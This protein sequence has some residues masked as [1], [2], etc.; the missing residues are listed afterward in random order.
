VCKRIVA[1]SGDVVVV[2][3]N[4]WKQHSEE[5]TVIL[6]KNKGKL[7]SEIAKE[8]NDIAMAIHTI[9]PGLVWLAGDNSSNS[10][11]SRY[12][13]P[14]STLELRGEV[15]MKFFDLNTKTFFKRFEDKTDGYNIPRL[16]IV[17]DKR[18]IRHEFI[19]IFDF[20]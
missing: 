20:S 19:P 17:Y 12:Y 5:I 7:P 1:T 4:F 18:N 8:F 13:G 9:G 11:D 15:L 14:V 10:Y 2:L 16:V 3:D 6:E